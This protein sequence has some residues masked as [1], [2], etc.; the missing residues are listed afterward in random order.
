MALPKGEAIGEPRP[1][2]H[3]QVGPMT[4]V[5]MTRGVMR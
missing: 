5:V 1:E 3:N 2:G 4:Q